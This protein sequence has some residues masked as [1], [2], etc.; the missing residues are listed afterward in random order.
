[1]EA[2]GLRIP[3]AVISAGDAMAIAVDIRCAMTQ[4]TIFS[5]CDDSGVGEGRR[6]M[7]ALEAWITS[8]ESGGDDNVKFMVSRRMVSCV[9]HM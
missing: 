3:L 9:I 2:E 4:P 5:R 7:Y 6:N 8:E 1:M